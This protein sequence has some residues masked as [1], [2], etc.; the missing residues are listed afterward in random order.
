MAE[1]KVSVRSCRPQSYN[2]SSQAAGIRRGVSAAFDKWRSRQ[3]CSH[4]LSLYPNS[5]PVDDPHGAKAGRMRLEQVFLDYSFYVPRRD[6]MEIDDIPDLYCDR[7]RKRVVGI[8]INI[9]ARV[10]FGLSTVGPL[11]AEHSS[12][13][14]ENS[15]NSSHHELWLALRRRRL[16]HDCW[17]V[18]IVHQ[19]VERW[20][21][22]FHKLCQPL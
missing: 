3:N 11:S 20:H 1:D 16:H 9:V 15:H 13:R 21:V 17:N 19:L 12:K 4:H 5:F 18:L 14:F 10:D 6:G 22:R 2:C 7:L 8:E